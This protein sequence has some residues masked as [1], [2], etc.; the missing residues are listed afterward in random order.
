M[1]KMDPKLKLRTHLRKFTK[2][3]DSIKQRVV[4]LQYPIHNNYSMNITYLNIDFV[5]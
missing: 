4:K 3:E 2:L 1:Q 5:N